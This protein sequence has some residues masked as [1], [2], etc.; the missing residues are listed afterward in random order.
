MILG[1]IYE[2]DSVEEMLLRAD[3]FFTLMPVDPTP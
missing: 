3:A 2:F 1:E